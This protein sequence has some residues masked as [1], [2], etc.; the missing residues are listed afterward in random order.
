V[1]GTLT[2]SADTGGSQ[3]EAKGL[4]L[5]IQTTNSQTFSWTTGSKGY[6]GGLNTLPLTTTGGLK[7]DVYTF[8]W[9]SG[10]SHWLYT[11]QGLGY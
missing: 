8:Y 6:Y 9:D 5:K 7:T 11:G 3:S 1:A 4:I 10:T 2:I